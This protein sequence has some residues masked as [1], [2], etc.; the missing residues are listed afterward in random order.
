MDILELV[1]KRESCRS[2]TGEPVK[3]ELLREIVE[4]GRLAP[5]ACN[6]QPWKFYVV[7]SGGERMEQMRL[8]AQ[9]AGNNKFAA[10]ASAFIVVFR[11]K[12]KRADYILYLN[13]NN[14]IAVVEA[15]DNHHAVSH[16]LQQAMT[17]AQMLDVPFAYSSNGDGFVEHDF[18]TGQERE[19]GLHDF[20][21]EQELIARYKRES[22]LTP[23]QEAM[24]EQPY[25]A[26]Q[27]TYPP[28]YYQRNA[29][30]RTVDAIVR[31]QQRILLVMAT[32]T[33]KTYTAFQ[34]VYR[35]FALR[36]TTPFVVRCFRRG[37]HPHKLRWIWRPPPPKSFR[38]LV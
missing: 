22:S 21:T 29:I 23:S 9:I 38:S 11:E 37:I 33:G 20:P 24:L 28:R 26:S 8:A 35:R 31:G 36:R 3:D 4:A 34:I 5:S 14:P 32:G 25:Y 12:P 10:K 1:K 7:M 13:E 30:N 18:L 16:G 17:Y 6:S 15:K 27:S 19:F 2:F